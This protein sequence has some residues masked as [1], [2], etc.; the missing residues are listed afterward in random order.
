MKHARLAAL[1]VLALAGTLQARPEPQDTAV[2]LSFKAPA[3]KGRNPRL[4][5]AGTANSFPDETRLKV[6]YHLLKEGWAP[7]NRIQAEYFAGEGGFAN[8]EDKKFQFELS[9]PTPGKC[10]IE[11]AYVDEVQQTE[12]SEAL[13]KKL[14]QKSWSF[15][16]LCWGDDLVP[17]LAPQL[18][19]AIQLSADAVAHVKEW[20]A[21]G[22]DEGPFKAAQ[23][24]LF[25]KSTKFLQKV[26]NS[27]AIRFYPAALNQLD[28][29][30]NNLSG[31][32]KNFKFDKGKFAGAAS[33]HAD[34]QEVKTLRNEAFNFENFK[35][36]VQEA[37]AIAGR[38]FLL[39]SIKEMRRT[40]GET[41]K[42]E[43]LSAIKDLAKDNVGIGPF[44]EK[45]E[46][47][48]PADLDA[49]EVAIRGGPERKPEE[50]PK[51]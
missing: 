33:Y 22:L 31:N 45:M 13:K 35:R 37:A 30:I 48:G 25:K 49:L 50:A 2:T 26:R 41:I 28:A 32:S 43:F 44:A 47:A 39:W 7:G 46:K 19:E 12:V 27:P 10:L 14:T 20:E 15:E 42:P 16:F 21:V 6:R 51:Q 36:Y 8:I 40:K 1:G 5:L 23:A 3:F 18:K 38:E 34:N 29:H 17:E 24:E 4:A 11:V 9:F